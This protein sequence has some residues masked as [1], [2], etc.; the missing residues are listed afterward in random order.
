MSNPFASLFGDLGLSE[1]FGSGPIPPE[2]V[3]R[4]VLGIG[5][6]L[7][8]NRAGIKAAFRFKVKLLR[9]DL[10]TDAAADALQRAD[11]K[12][13]MAAELEALLWARDD[14]LNRLPKDVTGTT[15][16]GADLG[17]RYA[18]PPPCEQC[19]TAD[20]QSTCPS[21]SRLSGCRCKGCH[22]ARRNRSGEP[23]GKDRGRRWA[24]YC[25][26]CAGDQE[27]ARQ[28]DLRRQARANRPCKSCGRPFTGS[29]SDALYC[30][31]ACRQKAYR[32]RGAA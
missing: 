29:R 24:G 21:A 30:S 12:G 1:F 4:K 23:Y 31:S 6:A 7:P 3:G 32:Q 26:P 25:W 20:K 22:G 10:P 17:S 27:N 2:S 11:A 9:P 18:P 14:L 28:R 5:L 13:N 16:G 19:V 8:L 15:S